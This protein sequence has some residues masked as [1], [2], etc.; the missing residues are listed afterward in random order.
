VEELVDRLVLK[1]VRKQ[2]AFNFIGY[3]FYMIILFTVLSLQR[4]LAN[5][6]SLVRV[7]EV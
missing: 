4:Q 6:Y 5:S 7:C 1:T 2:A 3:L